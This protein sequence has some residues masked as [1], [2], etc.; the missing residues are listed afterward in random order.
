M[1]AS[2]AWAAT[3]EPTRRRGEGTQLTAKLKDQNLLENK[4]LAKKKKN[5]KNN[6]RMCIIKI[7]KKSSEKH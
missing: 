2:E 4:E 7:I 1:R 5:I 6:I 3:A